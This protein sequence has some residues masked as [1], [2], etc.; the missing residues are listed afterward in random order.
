MRILYVCTDLSIPILGQHGAAVHVRSLVAALERGGNQVIVAAPLLNKSPWERPAAISA[1]VQHLPT[2]GDTNAAVLAIKAFNRTLGVNNTLPS[3]VRRIL[4][5]KDLPRQLRGQFTDQPPDFVY[6]RASLLSTA[7][8]QIARE[9]NRPLVIELN[10]PLAVEQAAYRRSCL[11][12]LSA[13]AER[14]SLSQADLV[15]VVSAALREYVLGLGVEACRVHVVPNGVD[16]ALFRSKW[17]RTSGVGERSHDPGRRSDRTGEIGAAETNGRSVLGFVG[18]LRPWHGVEILPRLIER[19]K[20]RHPNIRLVIVGDGPLRAN[21][22]RDF[23]ERGLGD[24]V[25]FTGGAPHE[26]VPQWIGRFDVALAPYG[27]TEHAFYFSPLKLFEYMACGVPTVA[28]R[29]GQIEEVVRHGETGLLYAPGELDAL[30]AA[31]DRLLNDVAL[32]QDLGQRAAEE[33][34][35]RYTWDQNAARVVELVQS[36]ATAQEVVP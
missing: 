3:E 13:Q 22:E 9:L 10:A 28:A 30:T 8:V 2:A 32:R 6:E 12:D 11:G 5:N 25:H 36:L 4:Y 16:S 1:R 23:D 34:H 31:C 33:I 19:L 14:W 18:G 21:L 26:E 35:R 7:G 20:P 24:H 15:L 27:P 29:L 17:D